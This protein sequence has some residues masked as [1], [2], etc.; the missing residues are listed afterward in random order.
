MKTVGIIAEYNPFHNGHLYQMQEARM[1]S[2]ADYVVV[3]MSGD[4]VQRGEPA[5]LDKWVRARMALEGGADLV[6][7]L[8]VRVSSGSAEFFARGGISLLSSL[9]TVDVLSFGYEGTMPSSDIAAHDAIK[10]DDVIQSDLKELTQAAAFFSREESKD[11]KKELK[12]LLSAG[13]TYAQARVEAYL[14]TSDEPVS[15]DLLKS[16]NNILAVE[17]LKAI[18]QL[19][20]S[21]SVVPV[22]RIGAGYNDPTLPETDVTGSPSLKCPIM[23]P[24]PGQVPIASASGIRNA[25]SDNQSVSAYMPEH[26]CTLMELQLT[27][28]RSLTSSD[29]DLLMHES[30]LR[31]R[32]HLEEYQ[33]VSPDLANRIRTLLGEYTGFESFAMQLKTRQVAL[34]RV[35]RALLH[36]LLG[37]KKGAAPVTYARVLGF[38]KTAQPLLHKISQE[39]SVPL[40]T[41]LPKDL[42]EG[43]SEDVYAAHLWEM[44]VCHKTGRPLYNEYQ[45]QL[46]IL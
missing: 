43:L 15:G 41:K 34:T 16:P 46:I 40:V 22:P 8:P 19:Q 10:S 39:S 33:D 3:A 44:L 28:N 18:R 23:P 12:S 4:F 27:A 30:L 29:L 35:K 20:S 13:M 38:R 2:G 37:I 24:D 42:P 7:E 1:R 45:R 32:D 11:Y 6:L 9:G 31:L 14:K 25:L 21:L 5:L 17:Y 26:V 36:I